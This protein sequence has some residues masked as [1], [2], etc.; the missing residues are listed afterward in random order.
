MAFL[1]IFTAPKPFTNPHVALIQRNAMRSWQYLGNDVEV[2]MIGDEP[3]M[4][5]VSKELKVKQ[6]MDV[7]RNSFGTPL[8]SSIFDS[9]RNHGTGAI[10][11]YVNTDILLSPGF[12]KSIRLVANQ[13]KRFLII[14]QRWDLDIKEELGFS[15]GWEKRLEERLIVSGRR[16]P[17]GGSDFFVYPRACF[18][19]IPDFALGRAGWDNW[20]IYHA[21]AKGW[22]VVDATDTICIVHQTHDYSHLPGGQPHYRLP[23]SADNLRLAGGRRTIFSLDD[24]DKRLVTSSVY[25]AKLSWKKFWRE[26][27][28][29]PLIKLHS[30]L[31]TQLLFVII[32]PLQAFR[33]FKLS[34]SRT[35]HGDT[36]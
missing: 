28:I 35:R 19:Q 5:A 36:N 33:E 9:G 2:L 16:H 30:H 7:Q 21:R 11:A 18:E 12:Q 14:G 31:L 34:V 25:P 4:A 10:F 15:G 22:P 8:L 6:L 26:I 3:G 20:M 29:F 13:F 1:T 27:E 17:R 23:E 32:H 24:A